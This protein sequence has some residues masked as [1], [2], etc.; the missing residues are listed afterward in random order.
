[1]DWIELRRLVTALILPLPLGLGWVFAGALLRWLAGMRRLGAALMAG[2]VLVV[3]AASLPLVAGYLLGRLEADF[4]P[5]AAVDCPRAGAIVVLGGAVKPWLIGD[6]SPRLHSGSDRVWVAA[7]LYH[8]GCAPLV[9]ISAGGVLAPDVRAPEAEAITS[10]LVDLGV[11]AAALVAEAESR[12]TR[13]NATFTK[14]MLAPRGID[15]VLLVTSAWHLRR[16]VPQFE[17]EGFEVIPVGAD[18][19]SLGSCRG[20]W[21]WLP[22]PGALDATSLALKEFLGEKIGAGSLF[23]RGKGS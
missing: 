1:M 4:P 23:S 3:W 8:A 16:A 12:D 22:S 5:M 14:A 18:Y 6:V 9:T 15:R 13:G 17:R 19:R 7:R 10:L 2:G 11:P 21:C 20:V